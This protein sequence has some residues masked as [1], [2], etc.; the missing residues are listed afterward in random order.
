MAS[1]LLPPLAGATAAA[2]AWFGLL[3]KSGWWGWKVFQL[4]TL[5]ALVVALLTWLFLEDCTNRCQLV[6]RS[7]Y[8]RLT[9]HLAFALCGWQLEQRFPTKL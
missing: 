8:H 1:I 2:V 4:L 9:F 3:R 5:L 7:M 6:S